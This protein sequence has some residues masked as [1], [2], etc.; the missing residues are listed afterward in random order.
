MPVSAMVMVLLSLS[1][2]ML[3]FQRLVRLVDVGVRQLFHAQFFQGV[4]SVGDEFPDENLAVA[5]Q[6][7]DDNVQQLPD[8]RLKLMCFCIHMEKCVAG[9]I[10]EEPSRGW[11][12]FNILGVIPCHT[13]RFFSG[14]AVRRGIFLETIAETHQYY[15]IIMMLSQLFKKGCL[16][17]AV[18]GWLGGGVLPAQEVQQPPITEEGLKALD[19][20]VFT[21]EFMVALKPAVEP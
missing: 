16:L 21:N 15:F 6:G 13:I 7:I 11:T 18:C 14:P 20:N 3:D 8:F 10:I 1:V 4:R 5:V 12:L 17:L 2:V 19:S 9:T